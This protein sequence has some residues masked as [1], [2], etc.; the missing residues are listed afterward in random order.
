MEDQKYLDQKRGELNGRAQKAKD[1]FI[2]NMLI[3]FEQ[4]KVDWTEIMGSLNSLAEE[5]KQI[6]KK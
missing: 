5:E 4:F 1:R 6:D 2:D 3:L